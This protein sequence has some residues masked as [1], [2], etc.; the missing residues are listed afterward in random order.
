MG[1]VTPVEAVDATNAVSGSHPGHRAAHAKG[2][3]MAATFVPTPDAAA[4]T[5]APHMQG[6]PVRATVRFSN[7]GGEPDGA[8]HAREGRGMAVKFY[9]ADGATPDIVALSSCGVPWSLARKRTGVRRTSWVT[10]SPVS[11]VKSEPSGPTTA[12]RTC[13]L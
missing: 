8:D 4:L 1:Q 5:R 9:L 7:G 13:S 2:T 10:T 11:M 12:F 3:L 6:D